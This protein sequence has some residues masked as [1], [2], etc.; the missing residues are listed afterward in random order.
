M[1]KKT[2]MNLS[3]DK[4]ERILNVMIDE[5]YEHG[6]ENASISRIVA[7]AGIAKGSFYQYFNDKQDMF[8]YMI[9]VMRQEKLTYLETI[10]AEEYKNNFFTLLRKL[11]KGG[12]AFLRDHPKQ[13]VIYD[14]FMASADEAVK[15]GVMGEDI[16]ASNVFLEKILHE[17]K[18]ANELSSD[19]DVRFM[20]HILTSVSLSFGEYFQNQ[21]DDLSKLK[22]EEYDHIV[23]QTI[24]LFQHGIEKR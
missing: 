15:K 6:Y 22:D 5:F 17:R 10:S 23:E 7:S 2:F 1:P 11:L 14:R 8:K 13:A 3:E 20:A 16:N 19:L 21:Y 4:K 9:D 24:K 18:A 12:L